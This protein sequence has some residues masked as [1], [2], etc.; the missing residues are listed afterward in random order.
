MHA[1]Q[2]CVYCG[3][4]SEASTFCPFCG[5][6]RSKWCCGCGEWKAPSVSEISTDGAELNPAI[7]AEERA[8]AIFCGVCGTE[9]QVKS[10]HK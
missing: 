10:A 6:S 7:T 2:E 9:L 1:Y 8:E 4:A 5:K 3:R